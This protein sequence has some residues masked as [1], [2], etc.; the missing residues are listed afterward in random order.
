LIAQGFGKDLAFNSPA[1]IEVL[2]AFEEMSGSVFGS[3]KEETLRVRALADSSWRL[4][5]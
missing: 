1:Q 2:A 3:H 5:E 4:V